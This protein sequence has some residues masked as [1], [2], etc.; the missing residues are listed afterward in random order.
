MLFPL[1]PDSNDIARRG[2]LKAEATAVVIAETIAEATAKA[3]AETTAK[4]KIV[5]I[6]LFLFE[7]IRPAC[8]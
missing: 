2:S 8:L 1:R 5:T 4:A 6:G 3:I 7:L